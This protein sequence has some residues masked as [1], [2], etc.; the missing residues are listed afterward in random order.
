M[1]KVEPENDAVRALTGFH[2]YHAGWSNC[3]MRVRM[4]LEEKGQEW[5]SHHLDIRK[6]EHISA[7]YFGIHPK[8]LVPALVHDGEVWIESNDII[9]YLDEERIKPGE[10]QLFGLHRKA[11]IELEIDLCIDSDGHWLKKPQICRAIEK[12]YQ[13][14]LEQRYKGHLEKSECS[15]ED[16]NR[17]GI[18]P[19]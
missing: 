10:V 6:G 18:G 19:F 8:G 11:E 12:R 5:T 2:L 15:F 7:E 3:S 16:R 1:P 13:K 14:T 4:V 9:E 17:D